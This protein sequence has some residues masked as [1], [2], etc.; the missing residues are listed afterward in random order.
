MFRQ[1]A[2]IPVFLLA[3]SIGAAGQ[4]SPSQSSNESQKQSALGRF[5]AENL[6]SRDGLMDDP[7]LHVY[8]Q[9]IVQRMAV[10]IGAK[11]FEV[12]ITKG[13]TRYADLLP[14]G[15]LYLSGGMFARL[16]NEAQ[17]AGL[18]AHELAHKPWTAPAA[19]ADGTPVIPLY[20]PP[21]GL[22]SLALGRFYMRQ[23]RAGEVEAT[24]AAVAALK[25]AGYEPSALLDLL[26]DITQKRPPVTKLISADAI[27]NLRA[28]AAT[29]AP[30]P[31]GYR[32]DSSEFATFRA[33][34]TAAL[35]RKT[36]PSLFRNTGDDPNGAH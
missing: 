7:A 1:P 36:P 21:C 6:E 27:L 9:G 13:P 35:P 26:S 33:S 29:G 11:P 28:V 18:L 12:R 15:V 24:E 2:L 19:P 32:V 31:G 16:E 4:I 8:V 25:D 23:G 20:V 22:S 10:S 5:V 34:V 30:P 17:L 14:Q 3:L